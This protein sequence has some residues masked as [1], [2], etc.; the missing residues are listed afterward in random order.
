MASSG[1]VMPTAR[2][3]LLPKPDGPLCGVLQDSFPHKTC[4]RKPRHYGDHCC[5]TQC[6]DRVVEVWWP[7]PKEAVR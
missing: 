2:A 7:R 4:N 5:R 3:A 6:G 1:G